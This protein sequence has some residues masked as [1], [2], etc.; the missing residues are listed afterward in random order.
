MLALYIAK[1]E[2]NSNRES[3][4][5]DEFVLATK[6]TFRKYSAYSRSVFRSLLN[7]REVFCESS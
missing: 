5:G 7:I 6:V 4:N 3:V 1:K 2:R